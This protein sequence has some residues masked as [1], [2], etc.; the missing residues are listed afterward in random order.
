M[1]QTKMK[2]L[3]QIEEFYGNRGFWFDIFLTTVTVIL[4]WYF[5]FPTSIIGKLAEGKSDAFISFFSILVGFLLT[6]FSLLFL[7]NPTHSENLTKIRKH[8]A[9]KQM[10][11]TFISTSF[12]TIILS[13]SFLFMGFFR[14]DTLVF[15]LFVFVLYRI[16][17]CLYYLY[18]I[19]SLS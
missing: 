17:K 13:V 18:A 15:I 10:L 1:R 4:F 7:Y 2:I 3:A 6:T 8:K 19:T 14:L 16:L 12:F 5:N 11:Y 9:Y